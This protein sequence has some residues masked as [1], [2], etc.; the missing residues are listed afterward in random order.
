[1]SRLIIANNPKLHLPLVTKAK[2]SHY[3]GASLCAVFYV[4]AANYANALNFDQADEISKLAEIPVEKAI[5]MAQAT[6]PIPLKSPAVAP[7]AALPKEIE[8]IVPL[9]ERGIYIGDIA[10]TMRGNDPYLD[11][12]QIAELLGK[13]IAPTARA[14]ISNIGN[15]NKI[16]IDELKSAGLQAVWD[17]GLL[18]IDLTVSIADKEKRDIEIAQLERE[19]KGLFQKPANFSIFGNIR[20]SLD[21]THKGYAKGLHDPYFDINL[22]GRI[23]GLAFENEISYDTGGDG[24]RRDATRFVFDNEKKAI[25]TLFGDVRPQVRGYQSGSEILGITIGSAYQSIQPY[26]NLRPR[27][28]GSFSLEEPSNVD[29]VINGRVVNRLRLDSGNYDLKDFPFL[30]GENRVQFIV[31]DRTGKRELAK[32]DLFFDRSL[33]AKGLAE[34]A[35]SAGSTSK[36]GIDGPDYSDGKFYASGFYRKGISNSVTMGGNLQLLDK[37]GL[38]GFEMLRAT[39]LGVFGIDL[40]NSWSDNGN[41]SAVNLSFNRNVSQGEEKGAINWGLAASARSEKFGSTN[42]F[43]ANNSQEFDASVFL[44]R[45]LG[46]GGSLYSSA[47]YSKSRG[48]FDDTWSVRF[49]YGKRINA[50]IGFNADLSYNK[51]RLNDDWV[52]RIQ[53]TSRFGRS[54]TS[55]LSYENRDQRLSFNVQQSGTSNYGQWSANADIDNSKFASGINAGAF[56]AA[57]RADLGISHSTSFDNG[58]SSISDERTSL[59][60]ATAFGFAD[61]AFAWG[62]PVFGAFAIPVAHESL[63]G[64]K[65]I[66]DNANG[67]GASSSVFGPP[68][69]GSIPNYSR[70]DLSVDVEDLPAGYDLGTGIISLRAP[71]NAGYKIV[72]GNADNLTVIARAISPEGEP[73]PFIAGIAKRTS[74]N[75]KI[76]IFTNG[77]GVFAASGLGPGEWEILLDTKPDPTIIKLNLSAQGGAMRKLGDLK[78]VAE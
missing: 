60:I 10:V 72:I 35:F 3:Y 58:F 31:E 55:V 54:G 44:S 47:N 11:P 38:V 40:A 19:D 17:P 51:N 12:K 22:G 45:Y 33:L 66:I 77:K 2:K 41:G 16:S 62:R 61:G 32:F 50:N 34:W 28:E 53:I 14:R 4:C 26:K 74:D 7:K 25:R 9:S 43:T 5:K 39:K 64:R 27:G 24:L 78:G 15:G 1:M 71:Y 70:R 20:T 30:E 42:L 37:S 68:L 57:N 18:T 49:G 36:R 67:N 8:I 73:I 65:L 23:F 63:K 56:L 6:A 13:I 29:V 69:I 48:L 46:G 52:F 76:D 59:R 75:K 21:Y